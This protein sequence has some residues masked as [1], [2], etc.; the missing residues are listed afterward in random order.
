[1][2]ENSIRNIRTSSMPG[3]PKNMTGSMRNTIDEDF[4]EAY[5]KKGI[6]PTGLINDKPHE[7]YQ[8]PNLIDRSARAEYK[9]QIDIYRPSTNPKPKTNIASSITKDTKKSLKSIKSKAV[10][11]SIWSWAFFLY[12]LQFILAII[13]L[14]MMAAVAAISSLVD[15]ITVSETDAGF[16]AQVGNFVSTAVSKLADVVLAAINNILSLFGLDFNPMDFFLLPYYLVFFIG[17]GTLFTIYIIYTIA[18]IK[19]LSGDKG[20]LK[21][22]MLLLAIIGY[23]LPIFNLFPWFFPWTLV[24]MRHP[25]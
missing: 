21:M 1:M 3:S 5:G 6:Q 15:S 10:T 17:L 18:L 13:G 7:K 9:N 2:A 25:E 8:Q 4:N 11:T 14:V 23:G 22:G 16:V 24:V 19:P 20:G 12:F